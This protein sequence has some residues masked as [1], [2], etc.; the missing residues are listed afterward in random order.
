MK[1]SYNN[2]ELNYKMIFILHIFKINNNKHFS[3]AFRIY[4]LLAAK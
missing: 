2:D 3:T 4:E 1:F